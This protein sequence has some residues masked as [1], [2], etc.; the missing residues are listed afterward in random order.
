MNRNSDPQVANGNRGKRKNDASGCVDPKRRFSS[1][2]RHAS[3]PSNASPLS[4][5]DN[6]SPNA[7]QEGNGQFTTSPYQGSP[8]KITPFYYSKPD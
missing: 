2:S 4:S 5:D 6:R 1:V 7:Y 3:S 8:G